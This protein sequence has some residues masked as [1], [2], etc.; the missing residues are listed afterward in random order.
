MSNL[1]SF[2]VGLTAGFMAVSFLVWIC[3]IYLDVIEAR[4]RESAMKEAENDDRFD[5]RH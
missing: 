2:C 1:E 3:L 5:N 4:N